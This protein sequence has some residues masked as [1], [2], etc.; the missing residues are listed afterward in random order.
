MPREI[1]LAHPDRH[2]DAK[3]ATA[4]GWTLSADSGALRI[5]HV[6]GQAFASDEQACEHVTDCAWARSDNHMKA[7]GL[8]EHCSPAAF[9]DMGIEALRE[10]SIAYRGVE[11][12]RY[13]A[14]LLEVHERLTADPALKVAAEKLYNDIA[15]ELHHRIVRLDAKVKDFEAH[16][17]RMVAREALLIAIHD[18][19]DLELAGV[20]AR[21]RMLLTATPHDFFGQMVTQPDQVPDGR[22]RDEEISPN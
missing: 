17:E 18:T 7:L 10:A 3:T 8:I 15:L 13:K 12:D 16:H 19:Q 4:E 2:Y 21:R 14:I 9:A 1:D 20:L 5:G 22:N 11:K 6:P